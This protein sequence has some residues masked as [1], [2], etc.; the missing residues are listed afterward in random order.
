VIC[1]TIRMCEEKHSEKNGIIYI[2]NEEHHITIKIRCVFALF[3]FIYL[4]IVCALNYLYVCLLMWK[5]CKWSSSGDIDTCWVQIYF[6]ICANI[7]LVE[8][9]RSKL[10]NVSYLITNEEHHITI[11]IRCV[12][13]LFY[14]IYLIIVCALNYLYVCPLMWK[15]YCFYLVYVFEIHHT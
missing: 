1:P 13:A 9:L 3:Y 4:I 7:L 10:E 6:T 14:F 5:F 11:K 2:T 8:L 15:T 12:F